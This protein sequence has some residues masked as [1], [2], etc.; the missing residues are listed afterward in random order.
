MIDPDNIQTQEHNLSNIITISANEIDDCDIVCYCLDDDK[1][2]EKYVRTV[3]REVRGSFE[4]KE[5]IKYLRENMGMDKCAV[6]KDVTNRE[7]YSIKIEIHHYPFSL[8]DIVDIVTRKR[9]YYNEPVEV[10]MVAKEVMML[11]Y[12]LIIGL[13]PLSETVHELVHSSRLFIPVD[14]VVG[15]YNIFIDIYKPF[16]SPEQLDTIQRMEKYTEEQ[17]NSI[18]NTNIIEQNRLIYNINDTRFALPDTKAVN[19][20]M[21]EQIK[22]IKDNNYLLPSIDDLKGIET[23]QE[24]IEP[25]YFTNGEY[26]E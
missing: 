16:C 4:Y 15:R 1:E 18:L 11:H 3:E 7:S 21:I 26:D 22:A 23:K 20:A 8:R 10:E 5:L 12:K 6:L 24:I 2:Y 13:I 17:T 14:R 9:Q 19:N 25:I